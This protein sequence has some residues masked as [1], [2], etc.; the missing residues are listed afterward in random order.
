MTLPTIDQL[1]T[2]PI[3]DFT[4]TTSLLFEPTPT[5]ANHLFAR[6]PYSS[7]DVFLNTATELTKNLPFDDRL[8]IINAHPRIGAAKQGLSA[9]SKKEQSTGGDDPATNAKLHDLNDLYEQKFGFRFVVFV[10]GRARK[11]I[12]PVLEERLKNTRDEELNKGLEEMMAIAWDRLKKLT[13]ESE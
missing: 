4:R 12:I 5:L 8:E 9:L 3:E 13:A 2:L 7:Y 6:R 11:E 1:N 10:A